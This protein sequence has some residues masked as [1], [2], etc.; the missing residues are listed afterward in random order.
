MNRY[1]TLQLTITNL[2][3]RVKNTQEDCNMVIIA[4]NSF[5]KNKAT[6]T[7]SRFLLIKTFLAAE[8]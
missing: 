3:E 7:K 5:L 1:S 4:Q 6:V 8:L 2:A